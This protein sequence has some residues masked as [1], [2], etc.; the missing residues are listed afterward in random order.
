MFKSI[1]RTEVTA[2]NGNTVRV[3]IGPDGS[4]KINARKGTHNQSVSVLSAE[5]FAAIAQFV[6]G[7]YVTDG[8]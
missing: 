1:A 4:V 3:D 5:Q 2:T 7:G 8:S 6:A